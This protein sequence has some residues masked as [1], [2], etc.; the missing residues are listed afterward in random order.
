MPQPPRRRF[1]IAPFFPTLQAEALSSLTNAR[2][3]DPLAPL[4]VVIPTPRLGAH[5]LATAVREGGAPMPLVTFTWSELASALTARSRWSEGRGLLP[6]TGATLVARRALGPERRPPGHFSTALEQRGFRAAML[7][8]FDDLASAGLAG[9]KVL[10]KFVV[11]HGAA[12]SPRV[13]HVF[14]LA[15]CHRR[16]FEANL[17]DE[18]ALLARAAI[19]MP[20]NT[21]A[22][23]G[24][25]QLW[26]YGFDEL[27]IAEMRLLAALAQD[28]GL[29][30][31]V[32]CPKS[33]N[34]DAALRNMLLRLGFDLV[35]AAAAEARPRVE[36]Q[37]L[38]APGEEAEAQEIARRL[39][40]ASTAGVPFARMAVMTRAPAALPIL[41]ETLD[42]ADVPCTAPT[43]FTLASR[44]AARALL[45]LLDL[46]DVGL[47][48]GPVMD[49]LLLVP[50]RWNA[51]CG[52]GSD[53]VT[54]A[55][56]RCARHA[57]LGSGIED[58]QAKLAR[59]ALAHRARALGA[60][61]AA[62][63]PALAGAAVCD[64]LVRVAQVL[65]DELPRLPSRATWAEF[66]TSAVGWLQRACIDDADT[67]AVIAVLA[68][69]QVL[70]AV[71]GPRPTR[72]EFRDALRHAMTETRLPPSAS[73]SGGVTLGCA[74]ELFGCDFD[75]VCLAGLEEGAWPGAMAED[76]VLPDRERA[77]INAMLGDAKALPLRS[78]L[79]ERERRLFRTV[80]Q[81]AQQRLVLS[82][83]RLDPATGAAR[84]PSSLLL[85]FAEAHEGRRLDY[86][87]FAR[88]S[89][90][91]RVPLRRREPPVAG[92]VLSLQEFDDLAVA[93]LPRSAARQY[94]RKLGPTPARGLALEALRNGRAR[95][96][97]FDGMLAD[98]DT[99]AGLSLTL[100][101]RPFSASQLASYATCPFRYFMR[102]EL[103]VGPLD[104]DERR[105]PS[106]LEVGLLV[107]HILET[108][109][110]ALARDQI[111]FETSAFEPLRQRLAEAANER[112]AALETAG[113]Q[114]A[115]LLWE[116]RKQQLSDDLVRFLRQERQR[117]VTEPGWRA[118]RFESRFGPGDDSSPTVEHGGG[119]L[120]FRGSIDR[121][122]V[123]PQHQGVRVVD[124]KSGRVVAGKR[125]PQAVQL[126][127]YLLAA[128]R[129]DESC[130]EQSEGRFVHVTRRGGFEVQRLPGSR[131]RARRQDFATLADD[132]AIGIERGEF[133]PQPGDS[134]QHCTFCDYRPVCDARIVRQVQRKN[135]AGQSARW[136]ALP[137]FGAELESLERPRRT[138]GDDG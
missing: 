98:A 37:A 27:R 120:R 60:D 9:S 16:V 53:P 31:E 86:E 93:S 89:W 88:L 94:V 7:R 99:R 130:L 113:Q 8:S 90:C 124:Y 48:P 136:L 119:I 29:D 5:L 80:A 25:R 61:E 33:A 67:Q 123:H 55:W 101:S 63:R 81:A 95:F 62:A 79:V 49:F 91:E 26:V 116:I 18:A 20:G 78:D 85:E 46:A 66:V 71:P 30:L 96:T 54:S 4:P 21:A 64:E 76:P 50:A 38:S 83:A 131:V 23:L 138:E 1:L 12:I 34:A 41:F 135:V 47:V 104:R 100:A 44:R 84:L 22:V 109:Y 97:A 17:D 43:L 15:I 72:A 65:A 92:P 2:A 115:R 11:R 24:R 108:F 128:S 126:V 87:A 14:E 82:Y 59:A 137:D 118:W 111:E 114:G 13:R 56:E 117:A 10:E 122:D 107:H 129:G 36:V 68:R 106:A 121:I 51:W 19:P 58:W 73:R 70:D 110:R 132:V 125:A 127:L 103:R 45:Q 57:R 69:L 133:F 35:D 102:H 39:L 52:I 77:S 32:Y 6:T 74:E 75:V 105:E 40:Q 134:G 3:L 42:A 112:F 28:P